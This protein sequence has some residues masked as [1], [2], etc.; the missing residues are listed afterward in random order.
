[1]K[2]IGCLIFLVAIITLIGFSIY[3]FNFYNSSITKNNTGSSDLK[4]VTIAKGETIDQI[5]ADLISKE[6]IQD[7][8]MPNGT[9]V[10]KLYSVLNKLDFKFEAGVYYLPQ[11]LSLQEVTK[12]LQKSKSDQITISFQEGLRLEEVAESINLSL[13]SSTNSSYSK[14]DKAEFI[15][16]ARTFPNTNNKYQFLSTRPK[17]ITSLEGFLFPD[18]YY[19]NRDATATSIIDILLDNFDKKIYQQ[20]LDTIKLSANSFYQVVTMASIIEREANTSTDR[21]II[22][23]I[24][25][26]R[27]SSNITGGRLEC[28]STVQYIIGNSTTGWWPKSL[29]TKDLETNNS[30]NTRIK[31]GLTP[32]PIDNPSMAS[33]LAVLKP[34]KNSYIYFVTG[35]DGKMYY[36]KTI[37]DQEL[38]ILNYCKINCR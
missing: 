21:N 31:S 16:I 19:V 1:M 29:T 11:N 26:R 22:A 38:N 14:F 4:V 7:N 23:D 37:A 35:D 32:T 2:K 34:Q 10:F 13:N 33:I 28:D 27:L 5:N 30:Y 36:A 18:T 3:L 25:L 6:I 15:K 24:F 9:S 8:K 12:Y 17:L 20:Y